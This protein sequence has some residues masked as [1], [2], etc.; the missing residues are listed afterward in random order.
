M[1]NNCPKMC[2]TAAQ[3]DVFD[4]NLDAQNS[5]SKSNKPSI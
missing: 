4:K 3:K 2:C 1:G 5:N